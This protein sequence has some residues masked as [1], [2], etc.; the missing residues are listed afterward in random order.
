MG[1]N[2]RDEAL[3]R[4]FEHTKVVDISRLYRALNTTSY[5]TVFRY[6]KKVGYLC[7][8]SH[9]GRYYTLT[10]IPLFDRFGLCF[11]N[12]ICFSKFGTLK[13]AV[14]HVIEKSSQGMTHKELEN[15]L[16]VRTQNTIRELTKS[17]TVSR[18]RISGVF[19]Y[20]S[21][22]KN[23]STSQ[24][25][26]RQQTSIVRLQIVEPQK[27]IEVLLE[28]LHF[29]NWDPQK[30]SKR[31]LEREVNITKVQVEEILKRYNLKKKP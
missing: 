21:A 9:A 29:D 27:I 11:F 20:V 2:S 10:H 31:L 25:E 16:R 19:V 28:L 18:E 22:D 3:K 7:S 13:V 1:E 17:K 15:L 6:L 23:K 24:L 30:I 8:Y 5:A 14:R 4:L 12:D 26:Q